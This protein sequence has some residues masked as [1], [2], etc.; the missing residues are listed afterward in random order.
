[1]SKRLCA[2]MAAACVI[3]AAA[4]TATAQVN[5]Y[6]NQ[7]A[8]PNAPALN[9]QALTKSGVAAPAGNFWSE[10]QND[11]GVTSASNTSAGASGNR[12]RSAAGIGQFRL[13]DDFTVPTGQSWQIDAVKLYGYQTSFTGAGSPVNAANLQI[14]NGRP[15]D[16][17]SSVIFGD[18]TTNRLASSTPTNLFRIFNTVAPPPGSAPGT[19]RRIFENTVNAG[20][21]L[22]PGTYWLDWQFDTV[23]TAGTWFMPNTTHEGMR[24][25]PGAN[26]RQLVT[27][28]TPA[29][30]VWQDSIDAGNPSTAADVNQDMPFIL[31]TI[32]EPATASAFA[33]L[34]FQL[35]PAVGDRHQLLAGEQG[36]GPG[37]E[38]GG[39]LG[40]ARLAGHHHQ[41]PRRVGAVEPCRDD[42]GMGRVQDAQGRA[43]DVAG[44]DLGE[45]LR[46]ETRTAHAR[47]HDVVEVGQLGRQLG[48]LR[49]QGATAVGRVD[50][51]EADRGLGL[52]GGPPQ[53]RVLGRE[54]GRHAVGDEVAACLGGRVG[55]HRVRPDG[56]SGGELD[57]AHAASPLTRATP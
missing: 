26:A 37:C 8:D 6:S 50:P 3:C 36:S 2:S 33:L 21:T 46:R 23:N 52:R 32:P 7:S 45:D 53:G 4:G 24:G 51:A 29:Q 34:G 20:I 17:G 14:W 12:V 48:Q 18:T 47:E 30:L 5:L 11:A 56:E 42:V 55:D 49:Q 44:E 39:L 43:A 31:V 41:R 1:M 13:A 27:A 19:T 40:A 22:G 38:A 54:L 57:L 10:V 16:A 35:R 15:G 9:P 28:G 25:V